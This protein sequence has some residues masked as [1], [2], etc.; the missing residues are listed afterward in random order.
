MIRINDDISLEDVSRIKNILDPVDPQDAAT[1]SWVLSNSSGSITNIDGG[2]AAS[3]Y[4]TTQVLDG[5]GA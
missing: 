2:L 3:V 1:K 5:G 4:L